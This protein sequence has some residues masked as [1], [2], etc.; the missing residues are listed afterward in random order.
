MKKVTVWETEI[1]LK[2][3]ANASSAYDQMAYGLSLPSLSSQC[4]CPDGLMQ[5]EITKN[6]AKQFLKLEV[7]R[8]L[9]YNT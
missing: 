8:G 6:T 9:L 2:K 4:Y 7:Q 1:P 5:V 3:Y